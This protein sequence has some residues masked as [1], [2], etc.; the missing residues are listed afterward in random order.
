MAHNYVLR[1]TAGHSYEPSAHQIVNV[2]APT[3]M[4]IKDSHTDIKLNVR[5]QVRLRSF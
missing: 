3:P 2:N 5:I 1:V 4:T